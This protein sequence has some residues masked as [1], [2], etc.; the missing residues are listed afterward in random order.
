MEAHLSDYDQRAHARLFAKLVAGNNECIEFNGH[1][2]PDGYGNIRYKGSYVGAHRLAYMLCVAD[3]PKGMLVL[4]SCDNPP[5]VN[6]EHLFLGTS[7]QNAVD[8]AL[9][10]RNADRKG[11]NNTN[12]GWNALFG[13]KS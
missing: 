9:K 12:A 1:C 3:I 6:P 10:G 5:C 11:T 13:G 2:N 7:K 8:R 4:H